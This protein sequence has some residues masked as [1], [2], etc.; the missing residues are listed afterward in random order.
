MTAAAGS[1]VFEKDMSVDHVVFYVADAEDAA[2]ELVEKYG[3]AVLARSS[4]GSP[5][6]SVAVGR[7]DIYLVFTE[8]PGVDH[9]AA[10]YVRAHG[11]GV[12]DI[13]LEVTDAR[14]AFA[15]AVR[16]GA[17]PVAEPTE[18]E[19]V[20]SAAITG[21]GDVVHSFVQRPPGGSG[22]PGFL[23]AS[24]PVPA[25]TGVR[26]LDHFAVC[27]EAGQLEPTV[28]FYRNVLDFRMIFE[29]RI[30]VGAQ[31]MDS[32]VV[33]SASGAVT[34]TLIEPDTTREPGQID[35]FLKNHGGAGVQH[36]A[37]TT[38]DIVSSIRGLRQRGVEFLTTPDAYYDLLGGRTELTRH[39]VAD[40]REQHVLVD[41]DAD[42]QLYQIFARSTHPSGTFFLEIIERAGARTFG[43]GNI[44]AVEVERAR[45]GR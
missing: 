32:K 16:R 3:L 42:G 12:A 28:T 22:L 18:A 9:P 45:A 34:L 44:E 11:D 39:P 43:S 38:A 31:S 21:F 19:G 27:L 23:P 33:Q 14:A 25:D 29:E 41:E 10:R 37:F 26:T 2:A 13:A 1:S 40:L 20:V 30:V 24:E 4:D 36:I 5:T 15:E 17:R 7:G 6:R 35:E 8:A